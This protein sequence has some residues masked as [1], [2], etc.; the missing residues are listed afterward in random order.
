M[1][2]SATLAALEE[3]VDIAPLEHTYR[4][5][6]IA[7]RS[8]GVSHLWIDLFCTFQGRD[9]ASVQDWVTESITMDQVYAGGLLNISASHGRDG[10]TGC[11]THL[12]HIATAPSIVVPWAK[13][14]GAE[15]EYYELAEMPALRGETDLLSTFY[16]TSNVF[17]RA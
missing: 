9:S 3:G 7:T 2:T 8:L 12:S 17:K 10:N 4:D 15:P 5:A 14:E 6:L 13:F 1:L 11:F 16:S